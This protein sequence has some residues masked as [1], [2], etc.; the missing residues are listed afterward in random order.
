MKKIIMLILVS[1]ALAPLAPLAYCQDEMA[2]DV[3]LNETMDGEV[4][5]ADA[6]KG[7]LVVKD[8]AGKKTEIKVQ[9][10]TLIL[11]S[12][13]QAKLSDINTADKVTVEYSKDK[14]NNYT[15]VSVTVK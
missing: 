14:L 2:Q 4:V 10:E 3:S 1:L 8:M 5:S 11:K 15:A 7:V 13:K 6:V 9:P 12:D